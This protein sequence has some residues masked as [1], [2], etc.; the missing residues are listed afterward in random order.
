VYVSPLLTKPLLW[1]ILPPEDYMQNTI[2]LIGA[3]LPVLHLEAV[4]PKNP[5]FQSPEISIE[6]PTD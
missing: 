5:H 2:S 6:I 4:F 3:Y 1:N